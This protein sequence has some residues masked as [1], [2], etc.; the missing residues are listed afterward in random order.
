[1]KISGFLAS[2]DILHNINLL[3]QADTRMSRKPWRLGLILFQP[4]TRSRCTS[5]RTGSWKSKSWRGYRTSTRCTGWRST[6]WRSNISKIPRCSNSLDHPSARQE[7]RRVVDL[8]RFKC[9][10]CCRTDWQPQ[11]ILVENEE[12]RHNKWL[13][14]SPDTSNQPTQLL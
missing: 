11:G 7:A 8:A 6:N 9:D 2:S 3:Q 12:N 10:F 14:A 4:Q 5:W 1:M 13:Q